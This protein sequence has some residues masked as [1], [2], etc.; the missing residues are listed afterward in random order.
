MTSSRSSAA[1]FTLTELLIT[2]GFLV[3]VSGTGMA[4][5]G[6]ITPSIRAN[7]QVNRVLSLM[8]NG[9]EQ[10]LSR[11]R[12]HVLRFDETRHTLSIFRV[13]STGEVLVDAVTF[14]YGVQLGLMV[15]AI[16]APSI[17]TLLMTSCSTLKGRWSTKTACR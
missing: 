14:E 10:A 2:V 6:S 8:Q 16:K 7:S 11:Q 12:L 17:S 15:S 5:L 13:E 9:R 4:L 1:G 3:V